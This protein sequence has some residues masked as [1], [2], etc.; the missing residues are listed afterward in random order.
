MIYVLSDIHGHRRRFDS[1]MKQIGLQPEDTLFVL[2]D[3]ID[4]NPDGVRILRQLMK[5][6]NVKMLLGNHEFMM[7]EA[8]EALKEPPPAKERSALS[9]WYRNGGEITHNH[10][11]HIRK[12]LR[13][14]IF[15]YLNDLPLS[16]EVEVNGEKFRLVH[17][18]PE[19]LFYGYDGYRYRDERECAV[20]MRLKPRTELP[21]GSTV[22]FGHTPTIEYQD[23]PI[24]RIYHGDHRIGID[25]GCAYAMS[26]ENGVVFCGRLACLRLDD[27]KEYYSEEDI[28][29]TNNVVSG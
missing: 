14:E 7:L 15:D 11:K 23:D 22:I 29:T 13:Q 20:W 26:V 25:C 21:A 27:M 19:E 16:Y 12:E 2:G 6:P 9:L 4:R 1:V 28:P 18:A 17:G 24:L 10:L 5:M 3:V 8:L